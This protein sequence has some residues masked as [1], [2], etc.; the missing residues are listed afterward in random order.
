MPYAFYDELP[1][2]VEEVEAYS[3]DEYNALAME[4]DTAIGERDALRLDLE[5]MTQA[6]DSLAMQLDDAK[7]KFADSF[8]SSPAK[9]KAVQERDLRSE[10]QPKT[11]DT[12]F[13]ERNPENAN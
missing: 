2:G 1:E 4:W 9:M 10:D 13:K 3:P 6:R 8:L 7:R 5:T 12:L 11:F